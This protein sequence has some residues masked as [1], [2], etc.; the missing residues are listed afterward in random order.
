MYNSHG[1]YQINL[2]VILGI[3][4]KIL[5]CLGSINAD[6]AADWIPSEVPFLKELESLPFVIWEKHLSELRIFNFFLFL[7]RLLF[8]ILRFVESKIV[9]IIVLVEGF[10]RNC[11]RSC[12][13]SIAVVIR[14]SAIFNEGVV[15]KTKWWRTCVV[16]VNSPPIWFSLYFEHFVVFIFVI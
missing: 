9:K 2:F 11:R 13:R 4:L 14:K 5:I 6:L 16:R 15:E 8:F 10:L 1:N 12:H 7:F 3:S